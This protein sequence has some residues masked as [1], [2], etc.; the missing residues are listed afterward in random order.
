MTTMPVK[1]NSK[2]RSNARKALARKGARSSMLAKMGAKKGAPKKGAP[3]KPTATTR[4]APPKSTNKP[5]RHTR[6]M[7]RGFAALKNKDK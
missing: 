3:Q 1:A 5:I 4:E 7:A 6:G 2:V